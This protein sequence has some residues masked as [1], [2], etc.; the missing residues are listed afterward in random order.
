MGSLL[1]GIPL[2]ITELINHFQE[3]CGHFNDT[4]NIHINMW[5]THTFV[6]D[7]WG[8]SNQC[9]NSSL[10]RRHVP[11]DFA[12]HLV[13]ARLPLELSKNIVKLGSGK[14]MWSRSGSRVKNPTGHCVL[15]LP[16]LQ[17]STP[18]S[19]MRANFCVNW[20]SD[21]RAG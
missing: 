19:A 20:R 1:C 8:F 12:G 5:R 14:P 7:A 4:N 2:A 11:A 10:D 9:L 3:M 15:A 17:P 21:R 16:G 13:G 6:Q 18:A